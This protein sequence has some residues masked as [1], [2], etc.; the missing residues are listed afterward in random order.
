MENGPG[1]GVA[2]FTCIHIGLE[3]T[4]FHAPSAKKAE[5]YKLPFSP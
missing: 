3:G 2:H 4:G 5:K 1:L